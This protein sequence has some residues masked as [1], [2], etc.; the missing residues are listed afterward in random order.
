MHIKISTDFGQK[1]KLIQVGLQDSMNN[2]EK[3]INI[4]MERL[5]NALIY[6]F[7][8]NMESLRNNMFEILKINTQHHEKM[9]KLFGQLIEN[10]SSGFNGSRELSINLLN[11]V[12][13]R[14]TELYNWL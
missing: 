12:I 4:G 1:L 7:S 13:N 11:D 6:M 8:N 3:T 5:D 2:F 9:M 14:M 10:A